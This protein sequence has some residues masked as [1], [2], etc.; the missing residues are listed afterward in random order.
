[1]EGDH[2]W[3]ITG[4]AVPAAVVLC[5]TLLLAHDNSSSIS[6]VPISAMIQ[7][8]SVLGTFI[9]W[10][11]LRVPCTSQCSKARSLITRVLDQVLNNSTHRAPSTFEDTRS[12]KSASQ[13]VHPSDLDEVDTFNWLE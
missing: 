13:I 12:R 5:K 9:E 8:L 7:Q 2:E 1:M 3:F 6:S 4:Y 11:M 10:L